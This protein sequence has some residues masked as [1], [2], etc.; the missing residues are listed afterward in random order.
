MTFSWTRMVTVEV[1]KVVKLWIYFQS[2]M[3]SIVFLDRFD[4][5]YHWKR[6]W[7]DSNIVIEELEGWGYYLVT[8]EDYDELKRF[9]GKDPGCVGNV[10]RNGLS[11]TDLMWLWLV[12]G[13]ICDLRGGKEVQPGDRWIWESSECRWCLKTWDCQGCARKE[14][15]ESWIVPSNAQ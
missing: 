15:Q 1:V 10:V 7:G 12:G 8:W 4:I 13:W 5:G 14:I 11:D 9:K 2:R 3:N 6:W